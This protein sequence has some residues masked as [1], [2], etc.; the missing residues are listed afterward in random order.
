MDFPK[1]SSNYEGTSLVVGE[2]KNSRFTSRPPQHCFPQ[3]TL[4]AKLVTRLTMHLTISEVT[5]C[6]KG[7][8]RPQGKWLIA[9]NIP[10]GSYTIR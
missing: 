10:T 8:S 4:H 6:N 9:G 3:P 5:Y 7:T 1:N 2:C